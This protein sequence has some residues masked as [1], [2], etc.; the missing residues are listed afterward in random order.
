MGMVLGKPFNLKMADITV[1]P[2]ADCEIPYHR[3]STAP[4]QR[5]IYDRPNSFTVRLLEYHILKHLPRI[6]EL[7]AEG[8]YPLDY[9][10]VEH[11]HQLALDYI[12]TIPAIYRFRN[13][14]TSFDDQCPMLASQRL[15]FRT[16][17]YLFVLLL[18]RPYIFSI[19]KSRTEIMKA[20]IHC[21]QSQHMFFATLKE[22]QYPMFTLVYFTVEPCISMLAVLISFPHDS[23]QVIPE[24][25]RCIR[26]SIARLNKIRSSNKAAGQGADII[27]NLLLR[28]EKKHPSMSPVAISARS[29]TNRRPSMHQ[30]ANLSAN[31]ATSRSGMSTGLP[32]DI[33]S[34]WGGTGVWPT[35]FSE[36]VTTAS[37]N[38]MDYAFDT[39]PFRPTAD[40]VYNDV[41]IALP[42]DALSMNDGSGISSDGL[43]HQFQGGFG[44]GSFWN[45]VNSG[46]G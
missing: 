4:F 41:G 18:H 38:G 33:G 28:A 31:G 35:S 40:L 2:P 16:I 42:E 23:L 7:E 20:G 10:K 17:V 3:H 15:N 29:I 37:M 24:A 19:S 1:V 34:V 44:E 11:I 5:T 22:N 30:Q 21:L 8:P 45:Y 36:P 14:D 26:E 27:Q 43:P 6:R 39:T 9:G 13:A 32:F 46:H 12:A 25:F